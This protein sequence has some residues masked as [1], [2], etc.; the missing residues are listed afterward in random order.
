MSAIQIR[1]VPAD[2]RASLV[3]EAE[4]RNQSLQVFLM[5]VLDAEARKID[6]RRLVLDY[7]AKRPSTQISSS[8]A[9]IIREGRDERERQIVEAVT[10]KAL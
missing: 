8:A 10:G 9:D 2:I 3:R 4:A 5:D 6:N 7:V 1:D